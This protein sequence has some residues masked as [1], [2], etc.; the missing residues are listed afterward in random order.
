M[1][2]KVETDFASRKDEVLAYLRSR[3]SEFVVD[4]AQQFGAS[5][6]KKRAAAINRALV[7]EAAQNKNE[8]CAMQKMLE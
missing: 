8:K 4:I 6:F 3:A 1:S 5:Q 7:A 2:L